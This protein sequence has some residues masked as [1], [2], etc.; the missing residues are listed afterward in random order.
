VLRALALCSKIAPRAIVKN[1]VRHC[2]CCVSFT[3]AP[4]VRVTHIIF[5]RTTSRENSLPDERPAQCGSEMWHVRIPA[6]R[7]C[8]TRTGSFIVC[9]V[10][11]EKFDPVLWPLGIKTEDNSSF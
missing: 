8:K 3:L 10:G 7:C 1:A 4:K 5:V 9:A 6:T 2:E 11:S